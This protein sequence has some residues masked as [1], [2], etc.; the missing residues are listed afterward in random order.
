MKKE[1]KD[2][3]ELIIRRA[4]DGATND[5]IYAFRHGFGDDIEELV[6]QDIETIIRL[7]KENEHNI[8]AEIE[9][10]IENAVKEEMIAAIREIKKTGKFETKEARI[11]Q[12][13]AA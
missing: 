8:G 4:M 1:M 13:S 2:L 12:V 6:G 10:A 11:I 5:I 7:L 9:S 3:I